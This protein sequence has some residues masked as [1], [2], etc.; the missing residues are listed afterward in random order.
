MTIVTFI[1]KHKNSTTKYYGKYI[2]YLSDDYEEGLDRELALLV[3]EVL[4][5]ALNLSDI[6]DL[7]IG[8]LH[9]DRKISDYFSEK[10]SQIF[11][12]LYCKWSNQPI[13][14]YLNNN[15]IR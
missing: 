7:I 8:I 5:D 11:D 12:L 4:K 14:V 15:L 13:E 10:E 2:G 1:Y 6:D 3:Y 9:C